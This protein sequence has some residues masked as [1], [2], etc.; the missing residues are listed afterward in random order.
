MPAGARSPRGQSTR[1]RWLLAAAVI[2]S[3]L[4]FVSRPGQQVPAHAP[5]AQFGAAAQA[6]VPVQAPSPTVFTAPSGSATT[7]TAAGARLYDRLDVSG[8]RPLAD[9]MAIATTQGRRRGFAPPVRS[10]V[11]WGNKTGSI[12]NNGLV[13]QHC[14]A[15][16][17]SIVT[18]NKAVGSGRHYWELTL[19]A[20]PGEPHP[21]T[22]TSPGVAVATGST[23]EHGFFRTRIGSASPNDP[24]MLLTIGFAEGRQY[25]SGDTFMFALD[26]NNQKVFQGVNGTWLNGTP[27]GAGGEALGMSGDTF[28]PIARLSA[29]SRK[30]VGDS[31]VANFGS[32]D[33]QFPIPPGYGAYGTY[34]RSAHG[35]GGA[36]GKGSSANETY[37]EAEVLVG[38]R[39]VP[40]PDG[41][42]VEL[43][44]FQ[45]RSSSDEAVVLALVEDKTVSSF[46][47]IRAG[48]FVPTQS[49][50]SHQD[51]ER[52]DL[53]Y[54]DAKKNEENGTQQCW[55][56]NHSG[57]GWLAEPA[58]AAAVTAAGFRGL[59]VPET[60]VNVGIR[61]ADSTGHS[62]TLYY[63]DPNSKGIS[64]DS[65]TWANSPW[66]TGRLARDS[67]RSD[68]VD[69]LIEWGRN[70]APVAYA[71]R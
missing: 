60:M 45:S 44:R 12:T 17:F 38:A 4:T 7:N 5:L 32:S 18:A 26:V 1:R 57:N 11:V 65:T 59:L 39:K 9:P 24:N 14:C 58:L 41:R 54:V 71:Y 53:L 37:R 67:N 47:A 13:A 70:W 2:V 8:L 15:G 62:V 40:L 33:F 52:P 61:N 27:G 25:R 36:T 6:P 50:A 46:I 51:C 42:W 66:H 69:G 68:Y 20:A 19:Q 56:V 34:T 55:W 31:W 35:S 29:S 63:V 64:T 48:E 22:Y 43:A 21:D 3:A 49:Y 30:P 10:S 23:T 16:A 28:L